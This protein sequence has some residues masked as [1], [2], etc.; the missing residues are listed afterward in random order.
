MDTISKRNQ[1]GVEGLLEDY[2]EEKKLQVDQNLEKLLEKRGNTL[3]L[4]KL[5]N[6]VLQY[7]I[8]FDVEQLD[9][10][11]LNL[12][13]DTPQNLH[14][15]TLGELSFECLNGDTDKYLRSQIAPLFPISNKTNK[16]KVIFKSSN[17]FSNLIR[18]W[19]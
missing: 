15:E 6:N 11:Q 16:S 17:A 9:G 13:S 3:F 19:I 10:L 4:F 7:L 8:K 5:P 1:D 18:A 14:S 12:F 2:K